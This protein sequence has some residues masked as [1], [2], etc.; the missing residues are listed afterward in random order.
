MGSNVEMEE[1][2]HIRMCSKGRILLQVQNAK[3]WGGGGEAQDKGKG[4]EEGFW[5]SDCDCPAKEQE[6]RTGGVR[7][8]SRERE[9]YC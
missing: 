9:V 7:Y 1:S 2:G 3:P 4:L 8:K 6:M 5:I